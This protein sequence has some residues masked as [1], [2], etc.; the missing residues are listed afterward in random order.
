MAAAHGNALHNPFVYDDHD[1][2]TANPSIVDPSNVRFLLVYSPFRPVVNVSY[3]L[4]RLAFGAGPEGFH[5]T[6][7]ALHAGPRFELIEE[8]KL[9]KASWRGRV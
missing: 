9:G 3:A 2:V 4:D 7:I 6:S 8:T 5:A 1:T